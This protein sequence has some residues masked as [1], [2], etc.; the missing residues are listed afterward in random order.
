MTFSTPHLGVSAGDSKLV[1]TGFNILTQWM[2][3]TSLKQMGMKDDTDLRK[4]FMYKLSRNEGLRWFKE[5]ILISSPQDTY[6]PFDSSRIQVS[7]INT[8]DSKTSSIFN[9]MVQS[10]VESIKC[11]RIRR[12]N[13]CMKFKKSSIDTF[14]GRA[15]HIALITDGILL[16]TLSYR[17]SDLL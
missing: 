8:S 3:H 4:S 17:Y 14:I 2:K 12:V 7:K 1:E 10:I 15:A 16:Q 9:E 11:H 5:V 6:S 13:I